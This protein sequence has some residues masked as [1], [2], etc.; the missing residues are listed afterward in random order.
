MKA[1][2]IAAV[3]M[4]RLLRERANLFFLFVLPM[5]I[6][7][8]LGAAFGSSAA[9]VAIHAGPGRLAQGLSATLAG[10][11]N[12][13]L[14]RYVSAAEVEH[15]VER[16]EAEAGILIPA[17]YDRTL[18]AGHAAVIGY[19]GRPD[20]LAAQLGPTIRAAVAAQSG[21]VRTARLLQSGGLASFTEG[22]ARAESTATRVP[23][24]TVG[25]RDPEGGPYPQ[26]QGRFATSASTQ[27][28]LFIF[29]TS[30]TGAGMLIETRRLGVARRMLATPTPLWTVVLGAGLGRLAIA[31]LQALIVMI[32]AVALGVNWGNAPAVAVL[33]LS[34]CLVGSG[35]GLLLGSA[36]SN[37][38]QA[39]AAAFLFGLGLA[40]LGGSMVPLEV[41]PASMRAI[42]HVT[43]HAWANEAFGKLLHHD[44]GLGDIAGEVGVLL[45]YAA[46]LLALST[47][48]LRRRLTRAS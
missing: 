45:A 23:R 47:W 46:A 39:R 28:L 31:V 24:V 35:A 34:F 1:L 9:R 11:Q 27:L 19:L 10:D 41:F 44:A 3:D 17:G 22:L 26:A 43:P 18:E 16:G 30:L 42:A 13:E 48:A 29:F 36:A 38:Q 32:G 14:R 4:R 25:V 33:V 12:L 15:A 2:E 8:L 37:E 20:T 21:L 7:L 5:L 40:A 6:I